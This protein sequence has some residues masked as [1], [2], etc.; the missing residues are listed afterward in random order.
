MKSKPP[1]LSSLTFKDVIQN[2]MVSALSC[3]KGRHNDE[4]KSYIDRGDI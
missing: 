2:L 1:S 3:I 4:Q